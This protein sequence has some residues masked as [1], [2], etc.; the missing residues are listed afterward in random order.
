M[1]VEDSL[2]ETF[3]E[4][5]SDNIVFKVHDMARLAYGRSRRNNTLCHGKDSSCSWRGWSPTKDA[6]TVMAPNER[7][8]VERTTRLRG[9]RMEQG[10]HQHYQHNE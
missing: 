3:V 9:M 10:Q 1:L 6:L 5:T 4:A 7:P 8:N 2:Q